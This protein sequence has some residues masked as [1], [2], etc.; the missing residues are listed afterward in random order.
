MRINTLFGLVSIAIALQLHG[1]CT[2]TSTDPKAVGW[3]DLVGPGRQRLDNHLAER[4][5][6]LVRVQERAAQLENRIAQKE[7]ALKRA[8]VDVQGAKQ[9]SARLDAQQQQLLKDIEMNKAKLESAQRNL[10]QLQSEVHQLESNLQDTVASQQRQQQITTQINGLE[11]EIA[12]L[13]R[14]IDDLLAVQAKNAV[15]N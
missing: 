8:A 13:E 9:E 14:T 15:M 10:D 6:E 3:C 12:T 2:T 1:C 5:A 7:K 4:R 11:K